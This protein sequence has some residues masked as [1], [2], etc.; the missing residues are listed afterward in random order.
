LVQLGSSSIEEVL[1]VLLWLLLLFSL[2][3]LVELALLLWIGAHTSWWFALGLVIFTGVLGAWLARHEG[4]RCLRRLQQDL[5][6]GKLPA[7]PLLDALMIL[8][9][10]ALLVTP[11]VLT[12]ALGFALL[13][14]PIRRVVRRWIKRRIRARLIGPGTLRVPS[15]IVPG[16]RP[17]AR[18]P[19]ANTLLAPPRTAHGVC[20]LLLTPPR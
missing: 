11:G 8:L 19:Q 6:R 2:V 16:R 18:S 5:A 15:A 13:V 20:L 4:L 12:D 3:P 9:A 7:D 17:L 1:R 10:G 14:S